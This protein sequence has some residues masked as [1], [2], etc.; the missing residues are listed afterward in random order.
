ML[1]FIKPELKNKI[2]NI[3]IKNPFGRI[4]FIPYRMITPNSFVRSLKK[5]VRNFI[6][7]SKEITNYT[8]DLT[9][10]N[11]KYLLS[12]INVITKVDIK[13]LEK[14]LFEIENDDYLLKH[15]ENAANNSE[16]KNISDKIAKY[17]RRIGWYIFVRALKPKVVVETGID[18]GLGSCVLTSAIMKN[19][20]EGYE[21]YYYGTDINPDAGFLL[22][23]PYSEFGKILYG[24]SIDSLEK[25]DARIDVFINDSDHSSEYEYNEYLT[26][27]DKLSDKFLIISDN[28]HCTDK[29][30]NFANENGFKYLFFKEEPL[31]HWYPGAGIG[32][33]FK[34]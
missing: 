4:L 21:G 14:Y 8:Y 19:R 16:Y 20:A 25:L 31:N 30:Y 18:K 28:A 9:D 10:L 1:K 15:I 3:L 22:K 7:H 12:F 23:P 17:G 13:I 6:F 24:D 5:Q 33:A 11:K 2:K 27:K 26:I 34:E 29:L 32:A